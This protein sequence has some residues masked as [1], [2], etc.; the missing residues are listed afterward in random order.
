[1]TGIIVLNKPEG[2]TSF[3]AV[4]R[5]RFLL[6]EKKAGH[7]GTLD[8]MA[9][10]VLPVLLGGATRFLEFLPSSPKTYIATFRP[11][12]VTDTLDITGTVLET[13]EVTID[14]EDV[15]VALPQFRGTVMQTPPM[16]SALKKDGVRLY[17]LAR[18][19]ETVEREARPVTIHK[20]KLLGTVN[21][22]GNTEYILEVTCSAGT[23][24][25]T[26]ID[27]L[28]RALGCGAV[29]TALERSAVGL[30]R[31]ENAVT[32]EELAAAKEAGTLEHCIIP[33]EEA[34]R[35]YPAVTVSEAQG[36]RFQNGGELDLS[37]IPDFARAQGQW[38]AGSY[39]R[40]FNPEQKFLGL[41]EP[42]TE[43][44]TMNVKRVF[45]ER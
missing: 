9:T 16:Y 45:V 14:R 35:I 2:I 28:G 13:S 30:F 20:L 33:M 40:L 7:C 25:R 32:L 41:G 44:G 5:T 29:M 39:Y 43:T 8:P 27:D 12:I 10:G 37:R 38:N 15:L 17:D 6:Q 21:L 4:S 18:K 19:G 36:V 42:D 31:L 22:D 24:I 11:G 23:Y 34:L 3:S 1:M 26:L